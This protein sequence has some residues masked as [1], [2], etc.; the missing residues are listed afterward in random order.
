VKERNRWYA[1]ED[2][3]DLVKSCCKGYIARKR[4]RRDRD[5]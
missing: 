5:E 3:M 1:I 4:I 2:V